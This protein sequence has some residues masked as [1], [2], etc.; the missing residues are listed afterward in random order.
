M[1]IAKHSSLLSPSFRFAA[2]QGQSVI[3]LQ[4]SREIVCNIWLPCAILMPC[5][6]ASILPNFEMLIGQ[7]GPLNSHPSPGCSCN[8]LLWLHEEMIAVRAHFVAFSGN[9]VGLTLRAW[10][11]KGSCEMSTLA[12]RLQQIDQ[13]PIIIDFILSV[14]QISVLA[15]LRHRRRPDHDFS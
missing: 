11:G 1:G 8:V 12:S 4:E 6:K 15:W 9:T 10:P 14:V 13:G 3:K 7:P 2:S 5:C